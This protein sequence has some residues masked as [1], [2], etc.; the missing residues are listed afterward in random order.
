[1][2]AASMLMLLVVVLGCQPGIKGYTPR[3]DYT[4]RICKYQYGFIDWTDEH[5]TVVAGPL[6]D[7]NVPFTATQGLVGFCVILVTLIIVPFVLTVRWK[8]KRVTP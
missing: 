4:T 6:G 2:K 5:S 1:M 8:E 7:F 3:R